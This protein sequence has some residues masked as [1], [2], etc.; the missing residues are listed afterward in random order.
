M[1]LTLFTAEKFLLELALRGVKRG[2]KRGEP[3]ASQS[4]LFINKSKRQ[5]SPDLQGSPAEGV[6]RIRNPSSCYL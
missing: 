1:I 6:Y 3:N 4:I 2:N 5:S